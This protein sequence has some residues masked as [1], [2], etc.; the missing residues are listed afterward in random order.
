MI[1]YGIE[2]LVPADRSRAVSLAAHSEIPIVRRFVA[3]RV[4]SAEPA[5]G[6]A[7]VVSSLQGVG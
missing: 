3:R 6:L 7:A 5:P 4:V 2:P 1:W